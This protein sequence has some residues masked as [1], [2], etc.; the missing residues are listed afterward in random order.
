MNNLWFWIVTLFCFG[1]M[2]FIRLKNGKRNTK[3]EMFWLI[4]CVMMMTLCVLI[5]IT[6]F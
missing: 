3:D 2:L 6:R 5:I 4:I 1:T